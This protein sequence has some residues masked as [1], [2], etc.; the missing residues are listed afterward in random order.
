L[1]VGTESVDYIKQSLPSAVVYAVRD[2]AQAIVG[3]VQAIPKIFNPANAF[4][5]IRDSAAKSKTNADFYSGFIGS[6]A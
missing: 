1:G 2:G 6:T 4:N 5:S 3:S